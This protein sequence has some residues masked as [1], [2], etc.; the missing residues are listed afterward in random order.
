M[1]YKGIDIYNGQGRP[2]FAKVKEAGISYVILK[3]TEGVDYVDPS[4]TVNAQAAKDAG[5]PIGAYHLL[6]ATPIDQQAQ[7]FL[8]AVGPY[9]P[10]MLAIDVEEPKA[11]STEIHDL[12]KSGITSRILTINS[13][14]RNAG[15]TCPIY[16]YGSKSWF[17]YLIDTDACRQAGMKIWMAAYSNDTPENT[18]HSDICDMWQWCSDGSVNG[19][20]GNV[21]M[22]VSYSAITDADPPTQLTFSNGVSI[23]VAPSSID[24]H[25]DDITINTASMSVNGKFQTQSASVTVQYQSQSARTI[26]FSKIGNMVIVTSER[27]VDMGVIPNETTIGTI[28][29]G[30]WPAIEA[31]APICDALHGGTIVFTADGYIIAEGSNDLKGFFVPIVYFTN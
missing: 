25:P 6:R 22:D 8:T 28:P 26:V 23:S 2:D 14:A 31:S 1:N 27:W 13:A 19:I 4:F 30:Y 24:I 29:G 5:L 21:D 10:C 15:Y 17:G 7:D 9:K 18:D 16:V 11:G 3:A 12:G 20:S